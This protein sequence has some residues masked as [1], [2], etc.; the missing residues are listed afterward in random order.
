MTRPIFAIEVAPPP[1][2]RYPTATVSKA[3]IPLLLLLLL[4]GLSLAMPSRAAAE[5][6]RDWRTVD[7]L[8]LNLRSRLDSP[9]VR[10]TA[11]ASFLR[12]WRP[13]VVILQEVGNVEGTELTQAHRLAQTHTYDIASSYNRA[14]RR[15]LAVLSRYPIVD[16]VVEPL[17]PRSRPALGVVVNMKG[18]LVSFVNVHLTPQLRASAIRASELRAALALLAALPG[19]G[20]IAGDFN[21]GDSGPE[22]QLI[23]GLR[24][25]YR[26]AHPLQK[27]FTWDLENQ[28]ARKNSFRNE[29]SRRLDRILYTRPELLRVRDAWLVLDEPVQPGIYPSDHFGVLVRMELDPVTFRGAKTAS[30]RMDRERPAGPQFPHQPTLPRP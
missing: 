4:L 27:G 29:P 22:N 16:V 17:P 23:A 13:D 5:D 7:V 25:A 12:R 28:L 19:P 3:T 9:D 1:L 8:T 14:T 6:D 30:T 10:E 24:D 21:F 11:V 18:R 15:G 26:E 2:E 20:F